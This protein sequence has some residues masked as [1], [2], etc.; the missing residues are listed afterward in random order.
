MIEPRRRSGRR[1][2]LTGYTWPAPPPA[3]HS[4]TGF[5]FAGETPCSG[6][7]Q[8]ITA[9]I[10]VHH[11]FWAPYFYLKAQDD[12]EDAHHVP[13][14][15]AMQKWNLR[16]FA[17]RDG[18]RRRANLDAVAGLD[19]PGFLGSRPKVGG[20]RQ[21]AGLRPITA[22]S[23]SPITRAGSACSR[24]STC[25][26]PH[27]SLKRGRI[28]FRSGPCRWHC[29]CNRA[30]AINISAIRATTR[31]GRSSTAAKPWSS[32]MAR[33]APVAPRSR[34]VRACSARSSR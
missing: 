22:R 21:S 17:R 33:T 12:W 20:E 24:R 9:S 16:D 32:S 29:A 10:Y 26:T 5:A 1:Q 15:P 34:T 13:H 23:W 8:N 31:S 27:T 19:Q 6:K 7:T 4:V 2:F 25:S 3:I 14:A 11:H 30:M 18:S 28:R